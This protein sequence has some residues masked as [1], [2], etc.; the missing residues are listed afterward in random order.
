MSKRRHF[1][2][3]IIINKLTSKGQLILSVHIATRK[4]ILNGGWA[5]MGG[6]TSAY[7][8]DK[9]LFCNFNS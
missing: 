5:T 9:T 3:K 4:K 8:V 2:S 1:I 7:F 6:P